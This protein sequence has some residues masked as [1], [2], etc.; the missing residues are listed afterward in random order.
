MSKLR[1]E[2]TAMTWAESVDVTAMKVMSKTPTAPPF[3]AIVIAAYG[4]TRPLLISVADMRLRMSASG[5]SIACAKTYSRVGR[6]TRRAFKAKGD[7]AHKRSK[8]PRDSK[9]SYATYYIARNHCFGGCRECFNEE[10]SVHLDE[11]SRSQW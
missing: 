3:P 7:G 1:I 8:A 5:T 10:A 11:V 9:V 6:K 2:L 4:K